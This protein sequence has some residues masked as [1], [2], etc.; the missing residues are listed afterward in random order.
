MN[1]LFY[2][3]AYIDNVICM[4]LYVFVCMIL[5]GHGVAAFR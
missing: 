3:N 4:Y 5:T 2:M 1:I